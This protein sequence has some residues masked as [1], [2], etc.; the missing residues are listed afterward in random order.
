MNRLL[1]PL[2]AVFLSTSAVAKSDDSLCPEML[3]AKAKKYLQLDSV[4]PRDRGGA[5]VDA[6]CKSWPYDKRFLLAVVAYENGIEYEKSLLVAKLDLNDGRIVA[7]YRG[8][9]SEDAI[10]VVGE[11]SL[12]L[13]TAKYQ[14]SPTLRAFG[15][16]FNSKARGPSCADGAYWDELT[17]FIQQN[18]RLRPVFRKEMQ[19][20]N[21]LRGCIGSATGH[22]VWEYGVRTISIAETTST[23]LADLLITETITLGGNAEPIPTDFA[24]KKRTR[25]YLM[26]YDGSEY[27]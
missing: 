5:V 24:S 27:R 1:L 26:K 23:G 13:D 6:A 25:S 16:R 21:A 20:Q 9:M 7:S 2:I 3:Y 11:G 10:K 18:G 15:V 17:L 4:F 22:D 14:L 8:V 12:Q 19:F